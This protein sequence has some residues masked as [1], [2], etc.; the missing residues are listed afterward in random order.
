MSNRR[1]LKTSAIS[2]DSDQTEA[3]SSHG[4]DERDSVILNG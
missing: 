3:I 1:Y 2:A 4:Q